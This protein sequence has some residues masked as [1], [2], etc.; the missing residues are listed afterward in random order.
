MSAITAYA[1]E[2]ETAKELK[3]GQ[4]KLYHQ[5]TPPTN[6]VLLD[7]HETDTD[8][9][10]NI[11]RL[12]NQMRQEL[13]NSTDLIKIEPETA[14]FNILY[15]K[16]EV[17]QLIVSTGAGFNLPMF[18]NSVLI[19]GA[20]MIKLRSDGER[21]TVERYQEFAENTLDNFDY[22]ARKFNEYAEKFKTL[23]AQ[24]DDHDDAIAELTG[25]LYN[26][27]Q[28]VNNLTIRVDAM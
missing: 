17:D 28:N 21:V 9:V 10:K 20:I 3:K 13:G 15:T 27:N 2:A 12:I 6:I 23:N 11:K 16:K 14:L 7:I 26:T 22:V 25:E 4:F 18:L 1:V 8:E 24:I 5:K 19:A